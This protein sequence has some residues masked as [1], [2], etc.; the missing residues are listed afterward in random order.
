MTET[1][2]PDPAARANRPLVITADN[3]LFE[4]LMLVAAEAGVVVEVAH[5]AIAARR[6][7]PRAT[8]VLVGAD[9]LAA[10]VRARL[11]ARG[12][13]IVVGRT[14]EDGSLAA[15]SA[16][17]AQHIVTLPVGR[18]WL[19]DALRTGFST[20]DT[21]AVVIA[22]IGGR[23]GAG[24]SV[25]AA[26]LAITGARHGRRVLLVDA[27]QLG[28]GT[29]LVLG[30]EGID[31]LR[32]PSFVQVEGRIGTPDMLGALP[33]RGDLAVLSYDREHAARLTP[34][35][36][37]A[38]LDAARSS[39]DIVIVDLPRHI[40]DAADAALAAAARTLLVVPAELRACAAARRVADAIRERCSDL[41]VVVRGPAPG[42]LRA[43]EIVALLGLPLA[44]TLR[45][46]PGLAGALE[47]GEAPAAR[48]G[49]LAGLCVRLLGDLGA[50]ARSVRAA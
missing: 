10:C 2:F 29:D 28:G 36:M 21:T 13:V 43:K 42:H 25:L 6:A 37:R 5:D 3:D 17:G 7:Y 31:G 27:D 41:C 38:T 50:L 35:A 44:G 8:A 40:D 47:R 33:Q 14:I 48:G 30:W 1:V 15:A 4:D 23:G 32:W 39:R 19:I 20:A 11:N 18:R 16:I 24:A 22:T 49:P 45:P 12:R 34:E 26:G 46:E 9:A